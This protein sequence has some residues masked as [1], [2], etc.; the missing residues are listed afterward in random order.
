MHKKKNSS[1]Y[2]NA[3]IYWNPLKPSNLERFT[4]QHYHVNLGIQLVC[5]ILSCSATAQSISKIYIPH[6][7]QMNNCNLI[8][9]KWQVQWG[10][11]T[12]IRTRLQVF[13]NMSASNIISFM[14]FITW[15]SATLLCEG[16]NKFTFLYTVERL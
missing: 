11:K 8:S 9:L 2:D 14:R 5:V 15:S 13:Y 7:T 1:L 3:W 12:Y 4:L 16:I 10:C 6:S